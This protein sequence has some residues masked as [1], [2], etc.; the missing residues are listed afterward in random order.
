M[1]RKDWVFAWL[2]GGLATA[3]LDVGWVGFIANGLYRAKLGHLMAEKAWLPAAGLFYVLYASGILYFAA[4]PALREGSLSQ[5]LGR[6]AALGLLVYGVYDLTNL[7]VLRD[8]GVA[9]SLLDV[10]W[11]TLLTAIASAAAYAAGRA[12]A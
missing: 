11:G 5:A 6:G 1:M 7:A 8:W 2:A 9:I 3:V 4:G 12:L 10:A